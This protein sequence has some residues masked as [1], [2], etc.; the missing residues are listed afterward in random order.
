MHLIELIDLLFSGDPRSKVFLGVCH[1]S[2]LYACTYM[3]EYGLHTFFMFCITKKMCFV[4]LQETPV[5][6]HSDPDPENAHSQSTMS[7][8]EGMLSFII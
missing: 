1:L 8:V 5:R 2:I 3:Y 7:D 6:S 4:N